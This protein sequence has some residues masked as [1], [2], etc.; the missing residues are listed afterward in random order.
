MVY[1]Q[2]VHLDDFCRSLGEKR[3]IQVSRRLSP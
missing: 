2:L 3:V 1:H